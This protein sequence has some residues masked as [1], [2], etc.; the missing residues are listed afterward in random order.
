M[1]KKDTDELGIFNV[2]LIGKNPHAIS[3]A[4]N[5]KSKFLSDD[6]SNQL[7]FNIVDDIERDIKSNSWF[8]EFIFDLTTMSKYNNIVKAVIVN[9]F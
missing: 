8:N 1:K 3:I 4:D 9:G 5:I 2:I 7:K 6:V